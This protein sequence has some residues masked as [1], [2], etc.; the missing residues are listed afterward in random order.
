[1]GKPAFKNV[2]LMGSTS[3]SQLDVIRLARRRELKIE[4]LFQ[5]VGVLDFREPGVFLASCKLI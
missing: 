5:L 3:C 4:S 1:M 2:F